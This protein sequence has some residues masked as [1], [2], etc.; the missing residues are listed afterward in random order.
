MR[1]Q[2]NDGGRKLA[3]YKSTTSDCVVRAISIVTNLPYQKVYDD[4]NLLARDERITKRRTTKSSSSNGVYKCTYTKY[5]E[6]LG[7]KWVPTM[8]IGKGCQVHLKENEL[9][10]GRLI[11]RLSKHLT[12]VIEGVIHDIY[13]P[14]REGTRCVYGYYIKEEV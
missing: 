4:I 10:K 3:G 14:D 6:K 5:L 12:S 13:N 9:P 8:F 2:Y 1:F 11:V 7:F